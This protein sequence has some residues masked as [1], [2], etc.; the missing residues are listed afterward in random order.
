[1]KQKHSDKIMQEYNKLTE[2]EHWNRAE[3][4]GK[5]LLASIAFKES[6]RVSFQKTKSVLLPPIG[7]YYSI[8]HMSIALCWLN[9]NIDKEKLK[10]LKHSTLQNLI[11]EHYVKKKILDKS[12]STLMNGLKREREYLNYTFGEFQND[13][14]DEVSKNDKYLDIEF[15]K[16]FKVMD[17]ICKRLLKTYDIKSR[18]NLYIFDAKGD[19]F[20]QTY[21]SKEEQDNV[22]DFI[23]KI[24]FL[25]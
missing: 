20:I 16:C 19:D 11:L 4:I 25:K 8:F 18:I 22:S 24:H 7:H 15:E 17:E 9:P 10:K 3:K 2:D 21:L 12:F 6:S 1:M 23:T 14:F 5:H 13:F